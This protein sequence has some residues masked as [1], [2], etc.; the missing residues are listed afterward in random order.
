[1]AGEIVDPDQPSTFFLS[2]RDGPGPG[3]PHLDFERDP[4]SLVVRAPEV[5]LGQRSGLIH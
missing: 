1:M 2:L 4:L 3:I 5:V